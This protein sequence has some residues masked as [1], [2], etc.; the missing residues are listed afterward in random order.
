M[1][2]LTLSAIIAIMSVFSIN[3]F[4][5]SDAE[6]ANTRIGYLYITEP[7][8]NVYE[9]LDPMSP[10]IRQVKKGEYLEL[11]YNGESWNKVKVDGKIGWIEKKAGKIVNDT[12]STPVGAIIFLLIIVGCAI[13]VVFL[14]NQKNRNSIAA[15]LDNDL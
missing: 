5:Q 12:N 13:V 10:L 14:V 6:T 3:S 1:R 4:A 15:G 2:L 9:K 8:A 7:F 11:V